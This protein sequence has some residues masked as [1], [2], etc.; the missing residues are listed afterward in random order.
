M[1]APEREQ[2]FTLIELMIALALFGL[3]AIAGLAM[4]DGLLGIQARTDGRLA[5][6]ADVQRALFVLTSDLDQIG[7]G[8][9]AGG[10][11][12]LAFRRSTPALGGMLVPVRYTLAGATMRREIAGVPQRLLT[13]VAGLRWRFYAPGLGW[14][15][16]WPPDPTRA[17]DWPVAVAAEM[18]LPPD[19]PGASGRLRRVV[20]LPAKP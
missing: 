15:D 9:L 3:I 10:G 5:R 1:I 20:A 8:P 19:L 2:G 18:A 12:E 14:I 4:V 16:R 7:A 17:G 13:G 6:L 11:A